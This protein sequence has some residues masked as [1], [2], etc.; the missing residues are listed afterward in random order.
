MSDCADYLVPTTVVDELK[1]VLGLAYS[2]PASIREA[3]GVYWSRNRG[4]WIKGET[5]GA[6]QKLLNISLDCDQ[7]AFEFADL[8]Y[9][10]HVA[11]VRAGIKMADV[12]F[13]LDQKALKV[14][15]RRETPSSKS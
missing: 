7:K 1:H 10:A 14:K 3:F 9:F 11:A 12:E 5:S 4:L 15:R 2:S 13:S 6:T 8:M